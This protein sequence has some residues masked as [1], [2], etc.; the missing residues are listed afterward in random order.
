M[1]DANILAVELLADEKKLDAALK[2]LPGK[3][4]KADA[5]IN[6]VGKSSTFAKGFV[7]QF[8]QVESRAETF[9]NKMLDVG[10]NIGIAFGAAA[11]IGGGIKIIADSTQAALEGE[12]AYRLLSSS[13]TQAGLSVQFLL[14]KS[15]K[16]AREGGLSQTD[17]NKQVGLIAKL[18]QAAG[19]P[20]DFDKIQTALLDTASARGL[21]ISQL[22]PLIN[23]LITG[24]S[25]EPLN[26][27]G[28]KDPGALAADYAKAVGKTTDA[29]SQKES[30]LSRLNPLLEQAAF[31]F[32]AN[33]D[34]LNSLSGQ[35]EKSNASLTDL[36]T[37]FGR[38]FTESPEFSNFLNFANSALETLT[39]NI[40]NVRKELGDGA[41]PEQLAKR[42][43]KAPGRELLNAFG[44]LF[45]PIGAYGGYL[46]DTFSGKGGEETSRNFL[47]GIGG[48]E[49]R[50][51]EERKAFYEGEQRK[52]VTQNQTAATR[53]DDLT[54]KDFATGFQSKID[55]ILKPTADGVEKIK[56][57][58]KDIDGARRE[59]NANL[60]KFNDADFAKAQKSIETLTSKF[61]SERAQLAEKR[62]LRNPNFDDAKFNLSALNSV[63]KYLPSE[64]FEAFSGRLNDFIKND[65]EK[66]NQKV[67]ELGKTYTEVFDDLYQRTGANNPLFTTAYEGIKAFDQLNLKLAG[68]PP[69]I[70]KIAVDLQNDL[71]FKAKL[72]VEV[73][74]KVAALSLRQDAANFRNPFDPEKQK[75]DQDEFIKRFLG[76]NPNYLYLQNKSGLDEDART[77]ILD[78]FAPSNLKE[79]AKDRFNKSLQ[80]QFNSLYKPNQSLEEQKAADRA[81]ISLTQGAN[82]LDLSKDVREGAAIA[83]ERQAAATEK[84]QSDTVDLLDKIKV[85]TE[86]VANN[87]KNQG[88]A[89]QSGG[90]GALTVIVKDETAG[91]IDHSFLP[92]NPRGGATIEKPWG[93]ERSATG[94]DVANAYS[95]GLGF[96]NGSNR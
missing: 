44:D 88:N 61:Y 18:A 25:D 33:A 84:Y 76:K 48:T 4:N 49:K 77:K 90:S 21:Q 54:T 59:L 22:E 36:Y 81:F 65:I 11:V 72:S 23:A 52:L 38:A 83:R 50:Y 13:A 51:I 35:L 3:L 10:S 31:N 75:K 41:T 37:N 5:D 89:V 2:G 24:S 96:F 42:D 56:I 30:V 28:L 78:R 14:D 39:T 82:P 1:S 67:K 60:A 94:Q 9:R 91:G 74:N 73:D 85:A 62:F 32:G 87:A 46:Y 79:T 17:A 86:A 45:S 55:A 71:N 47:S 53:N 26:N 66:G 58:A 34:R 63:E 57:Q 68:I 64:Q 15:E 6:Q 80:E 27:A 8:E 16:L 29:L 7:S 69:S 19:K 40:Q 93:L 92:D 70:K 12:K 20:E 43:A 95:N